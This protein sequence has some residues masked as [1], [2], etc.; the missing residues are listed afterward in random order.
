[1]MSVETTDAS[2]PTALAIVLE[3]GWKSAKVG[4]IPVQKGV[5]VVRSVGPASDGFLNQLDSL[6][7]T[8]LHPKAMRAE[9]RFAAIALDGDPTAL[10]RGPVRIK[11]FYESDDEEAYAE[12]YVNVDLSKKVVEWAEKDMDYRRPVVGALTR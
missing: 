5:V 9:T 6:Y 11:L 1:M 2:K 3:S 10:D 8:N 4:D 12:L 7:G